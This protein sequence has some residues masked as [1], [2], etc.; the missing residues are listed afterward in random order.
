MTDVPVVVVSN[1]VDP[2]AVTVTET[3]RANGLYIVKLAEF[4][5]SNVGAFEQYG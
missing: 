1:I 5:I 3:S 2:P 4:P